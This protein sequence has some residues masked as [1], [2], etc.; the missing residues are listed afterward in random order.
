MKNI[1]KKKLLRFLHLSPPQF[2]HL[3]LTIF[4]SKQKNVS[5]FRPPNI[6]LVGALQTTIYRG[7]KE[8]KIKKSNTP[9]KTTCSD[10]IG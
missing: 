2:S 10:Q 5:S 4:P 8:K 3:F 7:N 6:L 9:L 1:F